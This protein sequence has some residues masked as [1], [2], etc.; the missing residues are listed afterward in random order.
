VAFDFKQHRCLALLSPRNLPYLEIYRDLLGPRF[1]GLT[2]ILPQSREHLHEVIANSHG[3]YPLV[4]V[5]GGDGTIN[6]AVQNLDPAEQMLMVLPAGTGNDFARGIGVPRGL[7]RYLRAMAKMAPRHLDLWRC[8]NR[9]FLNSVGIGLDAQVLAAMQAGRGMISR[10]YIA[11]FLR[12]LPS[13]ERTRVRAVSGEETICDGEVWW[14]VALNTGLVGG[15]LRL[16]PEARL[17]D[18]LLDIVVI[19]GGSRIELLRKL[20]LLLRAAHLRDPQ[21]SLHRAAGF[22]ADGWRIPL[23]L[24]IDGEMQLVL[25]ERLQ[26][27]HAGKLSVVCGGE[28]KP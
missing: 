18:G 1:A 25:S 23:A 8:G 17:D 16:S 26:F 9:R 4:M 19:R 21:V 22:E 28:G 11:A 15:G 14:L 3:N 13:M 20:P 12:K 27:A 24:E 2:A 10:N 5:I 6:Q 7:R